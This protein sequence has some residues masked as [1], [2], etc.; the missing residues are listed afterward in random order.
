M[1]KAT[2]VA[3]RTGLVISP[4]STPLRRSR[5]GFE[6]SGKPARNRRSFRPPHR[7]REA[8]F[9]A[10][11]LFWWPAAAA[12][13]AHE[14]H[15]PAELLTYEELVLL[16]HDSP[17]ANLLAKLERLCATPFVSNAASERGVKPL[18]PRA[19]KLGR[20]I[21]VVAWNI[22]RGLEYEA[23]EA[24]F[25]GAANLNALLDRS[26]HM[27]DGKKRAH[28]LEQAS[29]LKE[30]DVI[31]LNEVDWGMKRTGYRNVAAE[32]AGALG[33]NY[34][35]GVEF[36]ELDP[37]ALGT[38]T[39]EELEPQQR[40]KLVEQIRIDP[41]RYQGLHGTAILSRLPLENVRLV[42]FEHQPYDWYA[43]ERKGV[44]PLEWG[45]RKASEIAFLEK[46]RRQIRRGG[47]MTLMAEVVD[48]ELPGGRMTVAA[49]HLEARTKPEGR[50][51]QLE[52][53]LAL[54][55]GINHTV[56]VAGDMNTSTQ[57]GTPT[58]IQREIKK[59]LGSKKFWLQ[60]GLGWLTG[61][62]I[63][64]SVLLK[65][66]NEYRKQADPTVRHVPFVAPNPEAK[67]FDTLKDFRF[68]DGGA[69]DFRGE[70]GRSA[71]DKTETLANSNERG[72]KGFITTYEVERTIGFVGRFKL[73]WM[74]VKPPALTE[75]Y[76]EQG[77]YR[78]APHFGRTLKL[79]NDSIE[80][81]ISVRQGT[82]RGR[83]AARASSTRR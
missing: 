16:S 29:L 60:K 75:P 80:D 64:R 71:G 46:V 45:K 50:V 82:R 21:R 26:E 10:L 42:P 36:V 69:F 12:Q 13:A 66:F 43:S 32:L 57:D 44:E 18:K 11:L 70:R 2:G 79:L 6:K 67:F 78:F 27:R 14:A 49:P 24:A 72:D 38:E 47:R 48:A 23:V 51:K 68:A 62:E 35:Y 53:V 58:S 19:G 4:E 33:M 54:L 55:K 9:S 31:V 40:A 77:A 22:E 65:G 34:A 56:V 1:N 76:A 8:L 63:P 20:V 15:R 52:E 5:D 37:I 39:F 28:V 59:R 30:A 81:R 7:W 74:F 25:G 41:E 73:D 61:L 83:A 17:P 3:R